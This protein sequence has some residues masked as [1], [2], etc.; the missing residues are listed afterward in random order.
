MTKVEAFQVVCS[1]LGKRYGN[2]ATDHSGRPAFRRPSSI[3]ASSDGP[4]GDAYLIVA[5]RAAGSICRRRRIALC[6]CSCRPDR[7]L[8]AAMIRHADE[9]L[10]FSPVDFADH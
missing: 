4:R 6:A 9:L 10:G 7:A 1:S 2:E 3:L 5:I 8:L